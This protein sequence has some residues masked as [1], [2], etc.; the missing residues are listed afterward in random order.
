M[1]EAQG[2]SE[3]TIR[4]DSQRHH[5]KLHLVQTFKLSRD[6]RFVEKLCDVVGLYLNPREGRGVLC[7]RR[8]QSKPGTAS[9]RCGPC[10]S[11]CPLPDAFLP[12]IEFL[13]ESGDAMDLR[14]H[15]Q[16]TPAW[17][18][19]ERAGACRFIETHHQKA[20]IFVW[21]APDERLLTKIAKCKEALDARH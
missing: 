9:I 11:A 6:Q 8:A 7:R 12:E 5:L 2:L 15:Q 10:A 4:R 18:V 14:D 1:A 17:V 21:S 20:Q 3:A 13:V 19:S 16:T